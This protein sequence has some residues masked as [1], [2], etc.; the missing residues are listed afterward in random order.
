MVKFSQFVVGC[1]WE[2]VPHKTRI[3]IHIQ[4]T[5]GCRWELTTPKI[6]RFCVQVVCANSSEM[7][8]F[9]D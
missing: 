8:T 2:Q 4:F 3:C 6:N 5:D 9:E 7:D 1:H